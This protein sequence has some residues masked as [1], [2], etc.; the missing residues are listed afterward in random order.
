MNYAS[1]WTKNIFFRSFHPNIAASPSNT[2]VTKSSFQFDNSTNYYTV[3]TDVIVH[4]ELLGKTGLRLRLVRAEDWNE[5]DDSWKVGVFVALCE[6]ARFKVP[7]PMEDSSNNIL[8]VWVK[9]SLQSEKLTHIFVASVV[10][11]ITFANILMGCEV[12]VSDRGRSLDMDTVFA[13]IKRPVAPAIGF[14]AQFLIMPLLSYAI[15]K[16][17]FVSRGLFSMAL[18]LFITGCSPGGG[19]SNFW[20]LLLDGNVNLSVTMT[21]ISTLASLGAIFELMMPFWISVFGQEFL[22]GFSSES[23]IHVPYGESPHSL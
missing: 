8:D 12:G 15:A 14:F 4:G 16:S 9:R 17:V 23:K 1:Q 20:T 21:F 7:E 11:L 22:Q 2:D 5:I 3:N 10:I 19:A 18:G 13:T 6:G